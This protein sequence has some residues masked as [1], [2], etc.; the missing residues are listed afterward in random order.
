MNATSVSDNQNASV[1]NSCHLNVF[2]Q[3]ME[4]VEFVLKISVFG[5]K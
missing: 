3:N 2:V 5:M 4:S 1:F